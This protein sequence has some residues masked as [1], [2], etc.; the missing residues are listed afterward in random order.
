MT[1]TDGP[2][3]DAAEHI[4]GYYLIDAPDMRAGDDDLARRSFAEALRLCTNESE[5]THLTARLVATS[6]TVPDRGIG[7]H[8]KGWNAG[9]AKAA[10]ITCPQVAKDETNRSTT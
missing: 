3:A 2:F 7:G 9:S 8:R 10:P 6:S 5:R 4:G 1:V